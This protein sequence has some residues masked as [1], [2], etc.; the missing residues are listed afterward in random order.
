MSVKIPA[1]GVALAAAGLSHFAKPQ[2]YDTMTAQAFPTNTR[3]FV[4]LNGSIETA[5]GAGLVA[6]QTRKFALAG[7]VGY[8]GYLIIGVV[9]NKRRA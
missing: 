2:I 3:R 7:V 9:R 6:P 4:Y 1:V 8:L 5:L